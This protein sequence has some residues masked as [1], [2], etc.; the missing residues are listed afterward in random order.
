[1]ILAR[2]S[3]IY[4]PPFSTETG[5]WKTVF[6]GLFDFLVYR[7]ICIAIE[8]LVGGGRSLCTFVIE[9]DSPNYLYAFMS[10]EK[11][12][13]HLPIFV[14]FTVCYI[15]L[16]AIT[17]P[18]L[19]TYTPKMRSSK[20]LTSVFDDSYFMYEVSASMDMEAVLYFVFPPAVMGVFG[21]YTWFP[22][23][24]MYYF[25]IVLSTSMTRSFFIS[26]TSWS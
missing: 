3:R 20:N 7:S 17:V 15:R 8:L 25:M 16:P 24:L 22:L 2:I 26:W 9:R 13:G 6:P 23:Y 21:A 5:S 1:M 10:M 11:L 4:F 19:T 18:R 12:R 14:N